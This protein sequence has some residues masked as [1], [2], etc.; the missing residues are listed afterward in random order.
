MKYLHCLALLL[1]ASC[2]SKTT[3]EVIHDTTVIVDTVK[4]SPPPATSKPKPLPPRDSTPRPE[5]SEPSGEPTTAD[6]VALIGDYYD[7][8][9]AHEYERAWRMWSNDGAAS[10]KTLREFTDGFAR[11]ASSHVAIGRPGRVEGAA[12]SRFVIIPVTL[13]AETLD[14]QTERFKGTFTLR[15]A[16]V[17]GATAKQRAWHIESAKIRKEK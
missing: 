4:M 11:T 8:I 14:G 6:A 17:D 10:G 15:R 16:V 2:T 1:L 5:T 13:T 7:A 9:N 12:G 3:P